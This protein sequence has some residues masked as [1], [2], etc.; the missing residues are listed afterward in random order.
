MPASST[1]DTAQALHL[2]G[3]LAEA[4][5]LYREV[6]QRQPDAVEALEGLGVLAY[7]HGR[8]LEAADFFRAVR[9]YFLKHRDSTP[10]WLRCFEILNQLD[11]AAD[12]LRRALALDPS[13]PDAWNSKGLIAH[14]LGRF[15]EAEAAFREAIRLRPNFV[16]AN[17][18]LGN[19]LWEMGHREEAIE[20]LCAALRIE[21]DDPAALTNLGRMLIEMEDPDLL[22]QAESLCAA[23]WHGR[24]IFPRRSTT[25]VMSSGSSTDTKRP[26]HASGARSHRIIAG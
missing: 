15:T 18:G 3:R 17:I 20:A 24:R 5:T 1:L 21:P 9:R 8:A 16:A 23:P 12:H 26:W 4:E 22:E 25:S 10:I 19:A 6:L 13:Q 11:K 7:Q 2:Q 14:D